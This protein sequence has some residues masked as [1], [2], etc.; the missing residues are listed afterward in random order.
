MFISK[1][2]LAEKA[3]LDNPGKLVSVISKESGIP[4]RTLYAARERLNTGGSSAKSNFNTDGKNP[5]TSFKQDG[6]S[7]EYSFK[8]N[9]VIKSLD[10]L[11]EACDIDLKLW[12]IERW[13]CNKWEVGAKDSNNTIQ[14]TPL[15]QVKVWLK[16]IH[17][18]Q[19]EIIDLIKGIIENT[20]KSVIK[21]P[22]QVKL[23]EKRALKVTLSDIHLGL[24]PFIEG[25]SI[26]NY[27]YN[28][29]IFNKNLDKVYTSILNQFS[30]YGKFDVL[31]IDDLGDGLDGWNAQTTRGGH[32]LDQ[33]MSN[34]ESFKY[35][36]TGKLRFIEMLIKAGVANRIEIKSV[37]NCN[38]SGS[39]G[40]IANYAIKLILSR[41]YSEKDVKC[42]LLEKF[43]EHFEYG[44]HCF[45]LTH[46]KDTKYMFK[47]LPLDLNDKAIKFIND[48]IDHYEIKSKYI[49]VVKG[50]LHQLG[51]KRTKK[52]DYRNY[53]SFAPPSVWQ[54]HNFG[55]AYS[56]YSIDIIPF[57]NNEVRHIDYFFEMERAK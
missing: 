55:D 54:Q 42:Y 26:F 25:K 41:S 15:F 10:E 31:M 9:K 47:G 30:I 50:D 48:Y 44:D 49:T 39:F 34:T 43:M 23:K 5:D 2:E 17:K 16:P 40:Y 1:G 57:D 19:N 33:N 32:G 56:G 7:A 53:M 35:Y 24:D 27:V 14:V 28:E 8:T 45:I 20:K 51:Y 22:N 52:F 6:D 38:H 11:V 4:E 46:G 12:Q 36:V 37:T 21:F 18:Q 3:I 13:V 29:T